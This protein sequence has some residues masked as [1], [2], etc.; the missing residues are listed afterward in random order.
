MGQ[1]VCER[2]SLARALLPA[3]SYKQTDRQTDR[4]TDL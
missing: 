1:R 4:Q 2:P 3:E